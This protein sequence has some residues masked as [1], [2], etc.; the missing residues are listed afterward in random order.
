MIN[1][2]IYKKLVEVAAQGKTITY[3][4]V[5]ALVGLE[6]GNHGVREIGKMLGEISEA[7]DK[8]GNPLLSVVVV[9]E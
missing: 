2:I 7:E 9:S 4:E 5:M 1:E 8:K 6:R 3:K